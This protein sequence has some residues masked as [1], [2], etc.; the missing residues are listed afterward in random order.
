LVDIMKRSA[1]Q[2]RFASVL[3]VALLVGMFAGIAE[4]ASAA[5]PASWTL[6]QGFSKSG[7][8]HSP[9]FISATR[10]WAVIGNRLLQTNDGGQ[11]WSLSLPPEWDTSLPVAISFSDATHGWAVGDGF[12]MATTNSGA[13]WTRQAAEMTGGAEWVAVQA[14]DALHVT[15][16]SS[17]GVV[18]RTED[19]GATWTP[20]AAAPGVTLRAL[21]FADAAHGWIVGA[22]ADGRG[23][24][25][26]TTDG[27]TTWNSQTNPALAELSAVH[28]ADAARGWAAGSGGLVRTTDGGITWSAAS[29]PLPARPTTEPTLHATLAF[30]SATHGFLGV[31]ADGPALWET[32]DGGITWTTVAPAGGASAKVFG[33][34]ALD[35][36]N[37]LV[38]GTSLPAGETL[39]AG[40]IW[41]WAVSGSAAAPNSVVTR[42]DTARKVTAA[43]KRAAA[44]R[45]AAARRVAAARKAAAAR[46]AAA[47]R[48]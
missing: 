14:L 44:R 17:S 48:R 42:A 7:A 32:L 33:L 3:L 27:G 1:A 12:I 30:V 4:T 11:R 16:V 28:F 38:T 37:V 22:D 19:G 35:A 41:K 23:L 25:L 39:T 31:D 24:I 15:V 8:V 6:L 36:T 18:L 13:H 43:A 26:A 5:T 40:G 46:R 21:R 47:R 20:C 45:A 29:W 34:V 9:T 10:G 2:A